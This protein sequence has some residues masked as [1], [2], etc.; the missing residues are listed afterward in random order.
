MVL[1]GHQVVNAARAVERDRARWI[2]GLHPVRRRL[3]R[4]DG[5]VLEVVVSRQAA[6]RVAEVVTLAPAEL[7]VR[8]AD[9]HTI[10]RLTGTSAHQGIAARTLP[11]AY[12][13]LESVLSSAPDLIVILDQVQDP[14]NFGAV[15]RTAASAGA[16]AVII[17][18]HGAAGVTPAVEKVAA[19][20]ASDVPVCQ[21]VNVV[22]VL[23]R[24]Q[25]H[26]FW[27]LG[28]T[29]R[30]GADLFTLAVP[31]RV[32]VILGGEQGLRPLVARACDMLV[33]I[34]MARSIESLNASVAAAI[35]LYEVRR[36]HRLDR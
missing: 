10:R 7:T 2:Y 14:H 31:R 26:G 15:L 12:A 27:S 11:F 3:E 35:V 16:A 19:G 9:E 8:Y 33:S 5:S 1:K 36:Q 13:D 22:R 4:R 17:P 34:P 23:R 21:V 28:L 25:G 20:A 24:L 30:G 29:P 18:R 6:R 32:A